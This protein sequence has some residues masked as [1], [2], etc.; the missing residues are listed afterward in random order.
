MACALVYPNLATGTA[1]AGSWLAGMPASNVLT[2]ELAAVARSTDAAVLSTKFRLDHGA[3]VSWQA[4][5]IKAHNLTS[6]SQIK[7]S[8][9]TTA[10]GTDVYAGVFVNCWNMTTSYDG[11]QFEIIVWLPSAQSARYDTIELSDTANPAG[12]VE[13]GRLFLGSAFTTSNVIMGLTDGFM[14]LSSKDRADSG[15]LWITAR[16]R[17]RT[18][19]MTL[20]ALSLTEGSTLHE[21]Q[22]TL[23]TID[24]VLYIP[25]TDDIA[26][27]QRYGYIATM[28]ELSAI[29]YPYY[30]TRK[31]PVRLTEIA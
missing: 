23:G 25:R 10:G 28:E 31:L 12:Y 16:T 9:G 26:Y 30:R 22:R 15:A 3:A 2:R 19:S 5:S 6:A 17:L 20:D 21:M 18:V 8:K 27:S 1:S 4:L 11:S 13:I 7:I 29:E 14:D 24:E